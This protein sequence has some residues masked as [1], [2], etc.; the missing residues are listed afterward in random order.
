M[1]NGEKMAFPQSPYE[2]LLDFSIKDEKEVYTN[3]ALLIP[4]F[5][6]KQAFE[7]YLEKTSKW[8]PI[9]E[10]LPK[11]GGEYLVTICYDL[12]G[13][14]TVREV[15][16][17][18]FCI[19]SKKWLYGDDDVTAWMPLPKPYKA[20]NKTKQGLTYADQDTLMSAT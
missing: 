9:S 10:G 2:F 18:F 8:I 12:L 11:E 15:R 17:N 16:R 7:H 14:G 5:R 6:A 3:G 13:E 20:E 4:T 19:L 1:S